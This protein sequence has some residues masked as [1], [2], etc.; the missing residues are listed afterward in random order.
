MYFSS[1]YALRLVQCFSSLTLVEIRIFSTDT[2]APLVDIFLGGL[3]KLHI[4]IV[5]FVLEFP[6]DSRLSRN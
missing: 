5:Y 4:I 3:I 6:S 1:K 2:L